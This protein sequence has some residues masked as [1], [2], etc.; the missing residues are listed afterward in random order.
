MQQ[1]LKQND[2]IRSS[3]SYVRNKFL[4]YKTLAYY[5][6]N[7]VHEK[8]NIT[9]AIDMT[10]SSCVAYH[11]KHIYLFFFLNMFLDNFF[12]DNAGTIYG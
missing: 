9:I 2:G 1:I 5:T 12:F 7:G 11:A 8:N 4:T 6:L 3:T 10:Y